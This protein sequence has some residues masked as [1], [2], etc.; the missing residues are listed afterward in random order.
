MRLGGAG[1]IDGV[2]RL[3]QSGDSRPGLKSLE[4][5]HRPAFKRPCARLL[6]GFVAMPISQ[7]SGVSVDGLIQRNFHVQ[8]PELNFIATP[9]SRGEEFRTR[10]RGAET[11][12]TKRGLL[13]STSGRGGSGRLL[14]ESHTKKR[15][16]RS[17]CKTAHEW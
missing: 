7:H 5:P 3:A 4:I 2:E 6:R 12:G 16:V 1:L 17:L 13:R 11:P 10:R 9:G 8:S 14:R 15:Y